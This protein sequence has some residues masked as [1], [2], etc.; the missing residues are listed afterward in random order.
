M[1]KNQKTILITG[2]AGYIGSHTVRALKESGTRVLILDNLVYGHR[3][4][5]EILQV[6]LIV[7]DISD[8]KLLD[9]IFT[10]YSISAVIHFAAFGYVGESIKNP[11][12]YYANNVVGTFTL[13]EAMRA[14][15]VKQI[16]FSSTCATYGRIGTKSH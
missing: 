7:G 14:A 11:A 2:G 1:F 8:R 16:V 4:L 5:V 10:E 12:K 13:L 6:P 15:S 9:Y 3:D